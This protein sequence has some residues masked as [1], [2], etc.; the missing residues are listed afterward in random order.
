MMKWFRFYN[1]VLDDPKVQRLH[2]AL[3]KHWVN[4]LCLASENDEAGDLP[5]EDSIAFRLRVKPCEVRKILDQLHAAGLLDEVD[6]ASMPRRSGV[7]AASR[8]RRFCSHNWTQRQR[9]SDN[10]ATRVARHRA[11]KQENVT[12]QDTLPK[13]TV[14]TDTE[15][16]TDT[17]SAN[18]LKGVRAKAPS[19]SSEFEEFWRE[20]PSGY[21]SKKVAFSRWRE[22]RPDAVLRAE[23][24]AGLR[25]WKQSERWERG[26]IKAAELW[27]RDRLWENPPPSQRAASMRR[28]KSDIE[29][30][31]DVIAEVFGLDTT[32]TEDVYE[33]TGVVR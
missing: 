10:S 12:L 16:E 31:M 4:L 33:T 30:Q 8:S 28:G 29:A 24:M 32:P 13:R 23:I 9:S 14:D 17:D 26:F 18:A 11:A 1:E 25:E 22:L 20:Y 6:D 19:Y 2:P 3:F 21:G 7:D 27:L 15:E 5:D